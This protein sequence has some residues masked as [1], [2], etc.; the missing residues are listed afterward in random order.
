MLLFPSASGSME[1]QRSHIQFLLAKEAEGNG[2]NIWEE[3]TMC[4]DPQR[5]KPDLLLKCISIG[6]RSQLLL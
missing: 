4:P 3:S 2:A 5:L 1:V 6:F